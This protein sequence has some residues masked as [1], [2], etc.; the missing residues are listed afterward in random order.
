MASDDCKFENSGVVVSEFGKLL[1]INNS[2]FYANDCS[3]VRSDRTQVQITNS[4]FS[5]G[6][7]QSYLSVTGAPV[8][9]KGST[10][11]D[12]SKELVTLGRGLSCVGCYDVLISESTFTD[13]HGYLGGAIYF[14][15]SSVVRIQDSGIS[16]N[17]AM[18]G[19]GI[20]IL[21]TDLEL[22]RNT[23]ESNFADNLQIGASE[24]RNQMSHV[25]DLGAGGALFFTC[26]DQGDSALEYIQT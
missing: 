19:G 9:I 4:D 18:Q 7:R 12:S 1:N 24:T 6:L 14:K 3:Q 20:Y 13:L 21:N 23:F 11:R 22:S 17:K 16:A 15:D 10:V 26:V 2:N 5:G 8:T 25:S